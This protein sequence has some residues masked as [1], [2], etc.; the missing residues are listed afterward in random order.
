MEKKDFVWAL[1][2]LES[3]PKEKLLEICKDSRIDIKFTVKY[4]CLDERALVETLIFDSDPQD[5]LSVLKKNV[6]KIKEMGGSTVYCL[7]QDLGPFRTVEVWLT[8]RRHML[9]GNY[10]ATGVSYRNVD[11][12]GPVFLG[13]VG[14]EDVLRNYPQF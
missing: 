14:F 7:P 8:R 9:L 2:V 10:F 4:E 1:K 11:V 13:V 12:F 6:P 5:L 3:L